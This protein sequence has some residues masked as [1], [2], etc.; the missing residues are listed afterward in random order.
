MPIWLES[1][2]PNFQ[3]GY[4]RHPGESE[5][6]DLMHGLTGFWPFAW[7]QHSFLDTSV[8]RNIATPAF[9]RNTG[10][11][12]DGAVRGISVGNQSPVSSPWGTVPSFVVGTNSAIEFGT[13]HGGSGGP[14]E[15]YPKL[16]Q[17]WTFMVVIKNTGTG[18]GGAGTIL[19]TRSGNG[20]EFKQGSGGYLLTVRNAGPVSN[21]TNLTFTPFVQ[22][23]WEVLVC[24][25]EL[26]ASGNTANCWLNG[27]AM[28]KS[29]TDPGG[30]SRNEG[31]VH[32][33]T[34]ANNTGLATA[35]MHGDIAA[36]AMW[37]RQLKPQEAVQLGLDPFA[38]FRLRAHPYAIPSISALRSRVH[39]S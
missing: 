12:K 33:L 36:V 29:G 5:N 11:S 4:A 9:Q 26:T 28:G 24:V 10:H 39:A 25:S 30:A 27:V 37:D 14:W 32:I 16:P 2:L 34:A 8:I 6:P 38:A 35:D 31:N 17:G 15:N 3:N 18:E 20:W 13:P 1:P 22:D 23:R 19:G 7:G 21:N